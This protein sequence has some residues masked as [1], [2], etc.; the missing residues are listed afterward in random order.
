MQETTDN[1]LKM[2]TVTK[3]LLDQTRY[4]KPSDREEERNREKKMLKLIVV[5]PTLQASK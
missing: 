2:A 3:L 5:N 4:V 1:L